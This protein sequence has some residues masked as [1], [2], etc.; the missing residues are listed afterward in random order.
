[1]KRLF[2]AFLTILLVL[3]FTACGGDEEVVKSFG[4]YTETSYGGQLNYGSV[5]LYEGGDPFGAIKLSYIGTIAGPS[6]Q[7]NVDAGG[8][9]TESLRIQVTGVSDQ[10]GGVM[11]KVGCSQA[12]AGYTDWKYISDFLE[13]MFPRPQADLTPYIT[14]DSKIKF[15]IKVLSGDLN[16][17][18]FKVGWG[19][20]YTN[21]TYND[22]GA[23]W[24]GY[25]HD[26][27]ELNPM[28][29]IASGPLD[30]WYAIEVPFNGTVLIDTITWTLGGKPQPDPRPLDPTK[31]AEIGFL[32]VF[33]D[34]TDFDILV[35]NLRIEE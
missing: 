13:E 24:K 11:M 29:Y 18:K 35:D 26:F 22:N 27:I 21:Y 6:S 15:V 7:V 34:A 10:T 9:G 3:S 28:D 2:F 31:F 30:G 5:N 20:T 1:M 32:K 14:V 17:V 8:D 16:D 19:I 33:A 12:D 23:P 25:L 4:I